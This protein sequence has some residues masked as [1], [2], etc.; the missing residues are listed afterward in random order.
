MSATGATSRIAAIYQGI[1]TVALM[2]LAACAV[3]A[4]PRQFKAE[5]R[6]NYN[7]LPISARGVR[8][9]TRLENGR[10]KLVSRASAF[11]AHVEET[12]EFTIDDDN[13]LTPYQY[14]YHRGGLGKNRDAVLTFDWES[15][16]V[17]N[18]VQDK[19]WTMEIPPG[20]QDKLSYQFKM[21]ADLMA[22]WAAGNHNPTLAYD[23][24]D[25][26][27]MKHY[28]FEV[29][30]EE[31]VRTPAGE[32]RTVKV[33][34]VRKDSDR[35]TFFWLAPDYDFLMVRFEQ[36]ED[37]GDSLKLVLKKVSFKDAAD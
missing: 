29:T 20:T 17:E 19:P 9:L 31:T 35:V 37:D 5:Y 27:S 33:T 6:A 7:G 10:Y 4:E 8:E 34:R 18:D 15:M 22:A 26:G 14:Q 24:A 16:Q 13:E 25:G 36:H 32:F 23:V 11:F 12:T 28:K 1:A 3:D 30:G 2:T 21:R